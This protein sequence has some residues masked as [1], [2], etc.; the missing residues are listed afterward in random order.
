MSSLEKWP[1]GSA[2]KVVTLG[3]VPSHVV[4]GI[5][6]AIKGVKFTKYTGFFMPK[7]EEGLIISDEENLLNAYIAGRKFKRVW[8]YTYP[9]MGDAMEV[10][11][12]LRENG[13]P[14]AVLFHGVPSVEEEGQKV[15]VA[16]ELRVLIERP[17]KAS[18]LSWILPE[19]P[20]GK[21][22]YA[23]PRSSRNAKYDLI[24]GSD[25]D[26]FPTYDARLCLLMAVLRMDA[27]PLEVRQ[28]DGRMVMVRTVCDRIKEG[29][30]TLVRPNKWFNR[31]EFYSGVQKGLTVT[32][33][34][35]ERMMEKPVGKTFLGVYRTP[36]QVL[37]KMR[38]IG[39]P[40]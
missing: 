18:V 17:P 22:D 20:I 27:L 7:G 21:V 37:D 11:G 2:V 24:C 6:E 33:E 40:I 13:T 26:V 12:V 29:T 15:K 34:D 35:G 4:D 38:G 32:V 1:T 39:L 19:E 28:I 31:F 36:E 23:L 5:L 30:V 14:A 3:I 8:I 9:W 16:P 10:A 25:C